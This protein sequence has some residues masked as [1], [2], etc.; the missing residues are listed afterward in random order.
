LYDSH[1][2]PVADLGDT[3]QAIEGA[4]ASPALVE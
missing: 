3:F 1:L 4:F 2:K